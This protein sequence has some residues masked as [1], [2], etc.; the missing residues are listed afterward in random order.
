MQRLPP[1][2]SETPFVVR[3]LRTPTYHCSSVHPRHTCCFN[4]Q[5]VVSNINIVAT[6]SGD[7]NTALSQLTTDSTSSDASAIGVVSWAPCF[8]ETIITRLLLQTLVNN[9]QKIIDDFTAD[10]NAVKD[11]SFRRWSQRT[12]PLLPPTT[13]L[14]Q[15]STNLSTNSWYT[16]NLL[17]TFRGL[18]VVRVNPSGASVHR[19][20]QTFHLCAICTYCTHCSCPQESWNRNRCKL[21]ASSVAHS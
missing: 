2:D 14:S 20:R 4:P 19:H 18:G 13:W 3:T 11:T 5:Q 12:V 1:E 9:F 8:N 7:T 15:V 17:C 6:F 16:L 21:Q 10:A